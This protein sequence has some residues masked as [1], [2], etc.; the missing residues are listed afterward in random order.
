MA[1]AMSENP[2]PRKC[3][4]CGREVPAT[5]EFYWDSHCESC[6]ARSMDTWNEDFEKLDDRKRG[7]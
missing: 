6:A 4:V 7:R 2:K 1:E 3:L 5:E